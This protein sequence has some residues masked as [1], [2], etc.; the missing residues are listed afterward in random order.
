[1]DGYPKEPTKKS[2]HVNDDEVIRLKD[3]LYR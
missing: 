2:N 1:M 3:A